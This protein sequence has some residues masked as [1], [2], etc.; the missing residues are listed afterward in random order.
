MIN[1]EKFF[2]KANKI[3]KNKYD[4]SLVDY[5]KW[6]KKIKIICPI[7]GIFEQRANDH[8]NGKG[9]PNCGGTKKL[10]KSSFIEKS[11]EVHGDKYDYSNVNY[12]N[13]KCKVE[14]KCLEHGF[15]EQIA[16]SHL[17]GFGCSKCTK[18]HKPTTTEFIEKIKKIHKNKYNYELVKYK[19]NHTKIKIVCSKHGVFSQLASSHLKGLG[20]EKCS[21]SKK[22][23]KITFIEKVKKIHGDKFD[24]SL[25]D[26]E[27]SHE[28]IKI[29]CPIHGTFIQLPYNHTQGSICP[30]CANKSRRIKRIKEIS[31]DKY[32]NNQI[33]PSFSRIACEALDILSKETHTYIQHAMNDGEFHV[34][35]LGYWVDGYDKQNNVVYEFDEKYHFSE[36]QQ[37]KDKIRQKEIMD[38]LNCKFVRIKKKRKLI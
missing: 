33:I 15:F 14:I 6:D 13:S 4:Y 25:V 35:E 26:Y 22:D 10:S 29:I 28:K 2:K 8:K 20:C 30:K 32:N 34:K 16:N 7:H 19:N 18:Q 12:I 21:K 17:Q 38:L 27:N 37:K 36:K 31:K 3:H 24:Y 5:E 23:T 11:I 1:I 9:C